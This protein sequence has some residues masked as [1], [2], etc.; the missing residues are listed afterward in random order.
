MSKHK[1]KWVN[2]H[3]EIC[4]RLDERVQLMETISTA[5]LTIL[6]ALL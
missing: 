2:D 4:D 1:V 3:I 6:M 5:S